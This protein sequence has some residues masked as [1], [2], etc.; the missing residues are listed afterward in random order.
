MQH[1]REL[2]NKLAKRRKIDTVKKFFPVLF[3]L[4]VLALVLFF[5]YLFIAD[6]KVNPSSENILL[7]PSATP[8]P[9]V[10]GSGN[11]EVSYPHSGTDIGYILSITG[12]ARVFENN[13]NYRLSDSAGNILAEGYAMA[14]A[15]DV[16]EF[17]PFTV[18]THYTP[19]TT[20]AGVLNVFSGSPKDGS[21][22]NIVRI[23][24]RFPSGESF[25][26]KIFL[27][28]NSQNPDA[29]DCT[30]VYPVERRAAKTPAVAQKAL[31]SLLDGPTT[32]EKELGYYSSVPAQVSLQA[33]TINGSVARAD[34]SSELDR[35]GG[36]CRVLNIVSQIRATLLQFPTINEIVIS[37]DGRTEDILQP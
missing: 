32:F 4:P 31:E 2:Y 14:N 33:I 18:T 29:A 37:V 10:S 22:I 13:F 12:R 6:R 20:T 3:A 36:S 25:S 26:F 24:I 23:P 16:G 15:P 8:G 19:P 21:E 7:T 27:G 28:S 30:L 34:F 5:S 17:G 9:E 11:I 1:I 35:T